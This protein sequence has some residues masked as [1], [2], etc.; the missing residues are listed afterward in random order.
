MKQLP[1][2]FVPE[3]DK[4][5]PVFKYIAHIEL[6]MPSMRFQITPFT[7]GDVEI[8]KRVAACVNAMDG[9]DDPIRFREFAERLNLTSM[10]SVIEL[11]SLLIDR[12]KAGYEHTPLDGDG[13]LL[14]KAEDI[15]RKVSK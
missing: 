8:S 3:F 10:E 5:E 15:L 6:T 11:L 7:N 14:R 13:A 4:A 9:I 2:W 1:N 12:I